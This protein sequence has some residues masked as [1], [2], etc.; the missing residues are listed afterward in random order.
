MKNNNRLL[1]ISDLVWVDY[2]LMWIYT[3]DPDKINTI[4]L[5]IDFPYCKS[6]NITFWIIIELFLLGIIKIEYINKNLKRLYTFTKNSRKELEEKIIRE[7]LSPVTYYGFIDEP[8]AQYEI[9][10]RINS[11][12]LLKY[13]NNR[14]DN[15]YLE[16]DYTN[17]IMA[18]APKEQIKWIV[19]HI[20][21]KVRN[22]NISQ[23]NFRLSIS[24]YLKINIDGITSQTNPFLT[25]N[26]L[27]KN[28]LIYLKHSDLVNTVSD[29]NISVIFDICPK[30]YSYE[31]SIITGKEYN[32]IKKKDTIFLDT[33]TGEILLFWKKLDI[34][35]GTRNYKFIEILYANQWEFINGDRI[36]DYLW[37]IQNERGKVLLDVLS[38]LPEELKAIIEVFNYNYRLRNDTEIL[39]LIYG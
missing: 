27:S 21:E 34:K 30:F 9:A 26:Y 5:G 8:D 19:S 36:F 10:Y 31:G 1:S 20:D 39:R 17:S 24:E 7:K 25:I 37:T 14:T 3:W 13:L 23:K 33:K 15:W 22:S 38:R 32:I 2:I 4:I 12:N 29:K 28:W 35:Y 18:I 11:E 6:N 16:L